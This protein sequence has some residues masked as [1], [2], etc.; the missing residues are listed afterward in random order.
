MSQQF[1][2]IFEG[3]W[4]LNMAIHYATQS[5]LVLQD[6]MLV[7]IPHHGSR[8]NVSPAVL[9]SLF[10]PIRP[11]DTPPHSSAYVSAPN[12][13]DTHPRGMVLNAFIRRGY[14][15]GATQGK[16]I[17]FWGGFPARPGYGPLE[18]LPFATRVED[19]D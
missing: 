2:D 5:G 18:L 15:I 4:G 17:V 6:F 7:Q 10:G 16:K 11:K 3:I 14:K 12:N 9:N 19:Y 1:R 8:R 13:D